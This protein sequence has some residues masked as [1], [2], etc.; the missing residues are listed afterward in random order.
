MAEPKSKLTQFSSGD[1]WINLLNSLSDWANETL[2]SVDTLVELGIILM[3]AALAW[4]IAKYLREQL[5]KI[6][7]TKSQ[8]SLLGRLWLTASR[9]AFPITWVI[10]L[11]I[12]ELILAAVE[13][14][15]GI[16]VIIAS[17]ITAWVIISIATVFVANQLG[18]K[19]I[20]SSA[21][22]VAALNIVGLLDETIVFLE[23]TSFTLGQANISALAVIQAAIALALLLW[24]TAIVGHLIEN[25]IK[26]SDSLTP[27]FQVLSTKLLRIALVIVAVI[28]TLSIVGIDLTVFAVFGG[29]IGVGLGF[30][31]QKIFA[32]LISGFILLV[33]KSIK[34]GDVI[35]VDDDYGTVSALGARYVSVLTR[36]GIE[37]LIPN[38]ELIT[39][40][41]ENWSHS[42]NLLRLRKMVGVHYKSDVRL[43]MSLCMDA[44]KETSRILDDPAP[45][46]LLV[47]FADNSVNIEM[48]YWVDDPMNG[49]ANVT[50]EL[51]LTVWDK[52]H[53]NDIEI[54]YPQRDLHFRSSDIN[55]PLNVEPI[56]KDSKSQRD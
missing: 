25:R 35:A 49:R 31:L 19:V 44:M 16:L 34:P 5:K 17:M 11:W 13:L 43:A 48:R 3:T 9:I 46:C 24:T 30:G 40:K 26:Q 47:D 32:N 50:S 45:N 27:S 39:T 2:A 7:T 42:S 4:P 12:S 29:A 52:F 8:V 55:Q 22:L 1:Y 56:N 54:P 21:W 15:H 20:A 23:S 37:H 41:V 36:D 10:A 33:D 14:R 51:M 6:K 18:R 28:F 38:E 53:E